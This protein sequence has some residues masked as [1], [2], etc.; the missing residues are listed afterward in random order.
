M[1][2]GPVRDIVIGVGNSMRRDDG[3]GHEVLRRLE[4]RPPP[5]ADLVVLDGEATRLVAAWTGRRRAVVVDAVRVGSAPGTVHVVDGLAEGLPGWSAG[6]SSHRAGLAEAVELGRA[7]GR[8]PDALVVIGAE[9]AELA[10][11][12]G[13]SGPVDAAVSEIIQ[14]VEAALA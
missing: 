3:L 5:D 10:R 2:E 6:A 14:R 11:G 8:L 7:L 4:E 1:I 12:P 13:L 9:P